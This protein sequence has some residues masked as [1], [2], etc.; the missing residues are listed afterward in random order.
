MGIPFS[1]VLPSSPSFLY[2]RGEIF[3]YMITVVI[4]MVFKQISGMPF[5]TLDD[6]D[7]ITR[8]F[9]DL[10]VWPEGFL[11]AQSCVIV[12]LD[13]TFHWAKLETSWLYLLPNFSDFCPVQRSFPHALYVCYNG[14]HDI[15]Y[16]SADVAFS[17]WANL[18]WAHLPCEKP[19]L[20]FIRD[21]SLIILCYLH[22]RTSRSKR[23]KD[24]TCF[25]SLFWPEASILD[26][27]A[28]IRVALDL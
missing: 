2:Y 26:L 25:S 18:T 4:L 19:S 15:T 7:S 1:V 6:D 24:P 22:V 12:A 20:V 28:S 13:T 10:Q 3:N 5:N 27:V 23:N 11:M 8:H 17:V 21:W 16:S 14:S 9:Q